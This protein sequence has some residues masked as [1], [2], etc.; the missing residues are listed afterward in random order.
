MG[1]GFIHNYLN[2]QLMVSFYLLLMSI[3][4]ALTPLLK[5][6]KT[7]M[8]LSVFFGLGEGG[9]DTACHAWILE[10]WEN[11]NGPYMQALHFTFGLGTLLAPLISFQFLGENRNL[12]LNSGSRF[13]TTG[14]PS[15]IFNN[16]DINTSPGTNNSLI[17]IP[18]CIT[19]ALLSISSIIII[20]MYYIKK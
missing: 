10:M 2:R 17:Y 12:G 8:V 18:Y 16:S 14:L 4:T 19:G 5:S 9:F 6:F 11:D 20:I 15:N 13:G 3:S 1:S 7:F